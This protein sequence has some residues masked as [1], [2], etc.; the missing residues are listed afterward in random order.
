[1]VLSLSEESFCQDQS[2][3]DKNI[4]ISSGV[5]FSILFGNENL[6]S[7][8]KD[9]KANAGFSY[10]TQVL[11]YC[12]ERFGYGIL[13]S[14]SYYPSRNNSITANE[15]DISVKKMSIYYLAPQFRLLT[16]KTM[17]DKA[18]GHFGGGVG[19]IHYHDNEYIRDKCY[20]T[21]SSGIGI[22][23]N[24]G[25]EY[26]VAQRLNIGIG[27]YAIGSIL[28]KKHRERDDLGEDV[29]HAEQDKIKFVSMQLLVEL[30]YYL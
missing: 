30:K 29:K 24:L 4:V 9:S 21:N 14:G 13:F 15:V 18:I 6:S 26:P 20:E 8:G 19:Y 17:I 12:K 22:N 23:A 1:M 10:N 25:I 28:K 11:A 27:A 5:G 16:K 7:P 2:K 3:V